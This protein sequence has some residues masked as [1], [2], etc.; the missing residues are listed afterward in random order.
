[1]IQRIIP[2]LL[3]LV[4]W[5]IDATAT[6]IFE[7]PILNTLIAL[8]ILSCFNNKHYLEKITILM[9][10]ILNSFLEYDVWGLPLLYLLP[11]TAL[12]WYFQKKVNVHGWI[13]YAVLSVCLTCHYLLL[14]WLVHQP[15]GGLGYTVC[16]ICVNILVMMII[17]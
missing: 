9:F 3:I 5:I 14:P 16:K 4:C 11:V 7:E 2:F 13:P 12:I 15:V 6:Y 1:M 8:Y 17:N 10:I